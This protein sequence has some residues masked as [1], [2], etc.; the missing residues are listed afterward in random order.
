LYWS[1]Q[2]LVLVPFL[3]L[4]CAMGLRQWEQSMP[5]GEWGARLMASALVL[6]FEWLMS[7]AGPQVGGAA[8]GAVSELIPFML[9]LECAA[10][11]T[12]SHLAA[13]RCEWLQVVGGSCW[14]AACKRCLAAAQRPPGQGSPT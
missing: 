4:L 5:L 8:A 1:L 13:S 12:A 3:R 10:S 14:R 11:A 2:H 6:A 7:P 9:R